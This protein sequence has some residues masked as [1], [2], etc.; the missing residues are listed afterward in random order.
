MAPEIGLIRRGVPT[1]IAVYPDRSRALTRDVAGVGIVMLADGYPG[2]G[3][4][5]FGIF[6][7]ARGRAH[8]TPTNIS[9]RLFNEEVARLEEGFSLVRAD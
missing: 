4:E 2:D 3:L 9:E 7:A 5:A 6:D 1:V 8:Y